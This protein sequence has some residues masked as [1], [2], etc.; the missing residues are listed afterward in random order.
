M[1]SDHQQPSGLSDASRYWDQ[2]LDP[3]NLERDEAAPALPLEDEIAFAETPDLA[4]ARAWLAPDGIAPRWTV[5]LGAGLGATAFALARKGHRVIAV[6]TSIS[7]MRS[8]RARAAKAGVA[9]RVTAVVASAEFLPFASDSITALYTRAVLIHVDLDKTGREIG[10]IL[11]PGCRAALLEP[12]TGNPFVNLYRKTL[13]PKA[14]AAITHYFDEKSQKQIAEAACPGAPYQVK[15]F[16]FISFLA[17]V[18]QFAWPKLTLFRLFLKP[19]SALDRLLF[20]FS[21]F[22]RLAWFG[23]IEIEKPISILDELQKYKEQ[24]SL[25]HLR[26]IM[27]ERW[28]EIDTPENMPVLIELFSDDDFCMRIGGCFGRLEAISPG[29][30]ESIWT[31]CT[32][33]RNPSAMIRLI[34]M[35]VRQLGLRKVVEKIE[36]EMQSENI[37]DVVNAFAKDL[38]LMPPDKNTYDEIK[39]NKRAWIKKSVDRV[40]ALTQSNRDS[41]AKDMAQ[42]ADDYEKFQAE[43]IRRFEEYKQFKKMVLVRTV[44]SAI[45]QP[46]RIEKLISSPHMK[47]ILQHMDEIEKTR[48][49]KLVSIFGSE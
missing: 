7:R 8:L 9:D 36:S 46:Q 14:W 29:L 31:R 30:L 3:Q 20:K 45:E 21:L 13:A 48:L 26:R 19:F 2:V 49:R 5:D 41:I 32:D 42:S 4:E 35:V 23:V 37:N 24:K 28:R 33:E 6:D 16:F 10:R 11:M 1:P 39:K 44:E 12:T 25:G 38:Y 22:R 18:F 43:D 40:Y 47:P 27:V 17:F 15:P 34:S